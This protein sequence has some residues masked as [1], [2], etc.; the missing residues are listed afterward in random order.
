[1]LVNEQE[2][3]YI[4]FFEQ[5][6]HEGNNNY[7]TFVQSKYCS[8]LWALPRLAEVTPNNKAWSYVFNKQLQW[9]SRVLI[10]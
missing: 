7:A 6:P 10:I 1:M 2:L 3:H 9:I 4:T 5:I 8:R